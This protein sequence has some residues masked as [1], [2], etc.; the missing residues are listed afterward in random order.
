[1]ETKIIDYIRKE[2]RPVSPGELRK[3]FG[4]KTSKS[5]YDFTTLL[6]KLLHSRKL[7]LTEDWKLQVN[8]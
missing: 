8:G 7:D 1:M 2:K 4:V 3:K 6:W 5:N